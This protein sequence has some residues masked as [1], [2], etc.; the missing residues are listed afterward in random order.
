LAALLLQ[1]ATRC[2]EPARRDALPS[3]VLGQLADRAPR[4]AGGRDGEQSGTRRH[5]VLK[6]KLVD[7]PAA[8]PNVPATFMDGLAA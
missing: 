7:A 4:Q 8:T 3:Q 5:R 1:D 6:T 2:I